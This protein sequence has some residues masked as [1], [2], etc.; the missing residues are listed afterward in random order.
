M[1]AL[2]IIGGGNMGAAV[3]RGALWLQALPATDI[4]R[5][6]ALASLGCAVV[7][8]VAQSAEFFEARSQVMLAI[9]PQA[10]AGVAAQLRDLQMTG[11]RLYISIMAGLS[12]SRI[13]QA[14]GSG[15]R[16]VRCMPNTPCQ[17]GKG[18]TAIALGMGS[19]E[20]DESLARL[21]FD[22]IGSTVMVDESLMNA[23]TAVSGSGPA[24][25]F[26]FAEAMQ[27]A[28]ESIDLPR[29]VARALV[30]QMISGAAAMLE[31]P[32]A[33]A[34]AMRAA[35]TSPGGTTAAA[36]KVFDERRF[37]Q[38]VIEAVHAARDRGAELNST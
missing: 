18:I 34:A 19:R 30:T 25:V 29:D 2:I 24:Y 23:V 10:F 8:H 37:R 13:H 35:V 4:C 36:L 14:L 26:L 15:T 20:G 33:D 7:A 16:V 22:A 27:Q 1:S 11:D 28:A 12:S 32:G 6:E 9:K 31:R 17:I 38:A 21:V 3:V 5:R